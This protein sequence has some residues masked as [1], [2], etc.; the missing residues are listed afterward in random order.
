MNI[1]IVNA[2]VKIQGKVFKSN[3]HYDCLK[4]WARTQGARDIKTFLFDRWEWLYKDDNA[5]NGF[6][7][8]KEKF[9]TRKQAFK[10]IPPKQRKKAR[11]ADRREADAADFDN[12]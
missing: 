7:D 2:A 1:V 11:R 4:V 8:Q 10:Y 9:Y 5:V 6:V 12:F 3:C